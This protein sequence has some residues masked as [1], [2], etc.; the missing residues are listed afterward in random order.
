MMHGNGHL[1][2]VR[3]RGRN[4]HVH[5]CAAA[6]PLAAVAVAAVSVHP[7]AALLLVSA[8][9]G[10]PDWPA[11]IASAAHFAASKIA[12][13][14]SV[15]SAHSFVLAVAVCWLTAVPVAAAFSVAPPVVA[16]AVQPA[17]APASAPAVAAFPFLVPAADTRCPQG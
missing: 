13:L 8:D 9:P 5:R 7:A 15:V 11:R 6:S 10:A 17:F 14:A 16:S 1:G 4:D 12:A 3:D 2:C